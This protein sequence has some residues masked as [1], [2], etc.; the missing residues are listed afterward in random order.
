[1][2]PK[3]AAKPVLQKRS[4][5][6]VLG[7][8]NA[9][10]GFGNLG[11]TC[12]LNAVLQC[13]LHCSKVRDFLAHLMEAGSVALDGSPLLGPLCSL[14]QSYVY[15]LEVEGLEARVKYDMIVPDVLLD[16][17]MNVNNSNNI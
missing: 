9:Y 2:Q 16:V 12:Y 13:L 10:P 17:I 1:M 15:G 7:G 5:A 6:R 11:N 4:L 3:D 8:D 14:T